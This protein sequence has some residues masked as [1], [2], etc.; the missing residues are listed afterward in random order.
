MN[1]I[2]VR[3]NT[4]FY[5]LGHLNILE[6]G[7]FKFCLS[8]CSFSYLFI[9]LCCGCVCVNFIREKRNRTKVKCSFDSFIIVI[10]VV[11]I[12]VIFIVI[13]TTIYWGSSSGSRQDVILCQNG[14]MSHEKQWNDL[15][16]YV[17][18]GVIVYPQPRMHNSVGWAWSR[19][20]A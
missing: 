3:S 2:Q 13:I 4:V 19:V 20:D 9:Y 16:I 15:H 8:S 17:K 5:Q 18:S 1:K 10:I 12:I 14:L 6:L 7:N 11:V